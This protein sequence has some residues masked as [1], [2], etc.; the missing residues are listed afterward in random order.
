MD[1]N[2][3]KDYKSFVRK[4]MDLGTIKQKMNSYRSP[5]QFEDD[6][7]LV[8]SNARSYNPEGTDV[9]R[10]ADA[11]E[12]KFSE[13]WTRN[14]LPKLNEEQRICMEEERTLRQS[15]ASLLVMKTEGD[16]DYI[17]GQLLE[18]LEV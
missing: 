13:K 14:I 9:R 12:E 18:R 11:V 16:I 4:P 7:R 3:Y 6:V 1:V 10:M 15:K 5:H 2:V 17:C 8:F